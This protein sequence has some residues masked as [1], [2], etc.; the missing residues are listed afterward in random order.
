M[1]VYP[2]VKPLIF[3][4]LVAL[5]VITGLWLDRRRATTLGRAEARIE[6]L[7]RDNIRLAAAARRTDSVFVRDTLRL[8]RT[9]TRFRTVV[10]SLVRTDTLTVREQ[11]IVATADSALHACAD[12][13]A[14]CTARVAARDSVIRLLGDQRDAERAYYRAKLAAATPRIRTELDAATNPFDPTTFSAA[15]TVS[16]RLLGPISVTAG[17]QYWTFDTHQSLAPVV[18]V[19]VVLR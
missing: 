9:V 7:A 5:L 10:D 17:A 15:A 18:G 4:G 11:V 1:F 16:L 14:S 3:G 19:R 8:T 12:V 2:W 6:Q 13:V